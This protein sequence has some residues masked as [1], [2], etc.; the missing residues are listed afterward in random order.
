MDDEKVH[1]KLDKIIDKVSKLEI[2]AVQ[3]EETLKHHVYRTDLAEENI[4]MLRLDVAP[5]TR[6][7][8]N[9]IGAA[10]WTTLLLTIAGIVLGAL[11]LRSH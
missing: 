9:F 4:E 8:D 10:K 5:L 2:T 6:F 11:K 7:K 3:H 1:A